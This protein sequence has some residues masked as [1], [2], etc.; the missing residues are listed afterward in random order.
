MVFR[1]VML[2]LGAKGPAIMHS[3]NPKDR[4]LTQNAAEQRC[5]WKNRRAGNV[6]AGGVLRINH[7]E[8][9]WWHVLR[10][11]VAPALS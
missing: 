10:E 5:L 8:G 9:Y 7:P 3:G 2:R 1:V 4:G 11:D 6:M